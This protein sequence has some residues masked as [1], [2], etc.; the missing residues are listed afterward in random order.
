MAQKMSDTF[1]MK[2]LDSQNHEVL[3][4]GDVETASEESNCCGV[5][6]TISNCPLRFFRRLQGII[7]RRRTEILFMVIFSVLLPLAD[8][9]SDLYSAIRYF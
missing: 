2:N 8:E 1:G 7:G 9:G 5:F 6:K 3:D 4:L